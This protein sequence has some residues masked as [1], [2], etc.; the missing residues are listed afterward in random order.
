ML[1]SYLAGATNCIAGTG[2]APAVTACLRQDPFAA[3][4]VGALGL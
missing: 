1:R 3:E 4:L 2:A